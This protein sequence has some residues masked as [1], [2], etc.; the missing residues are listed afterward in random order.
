MDA[1]LHDPV[2]GDLVS[3]H[4]IFVQVVEV[5]KSCRRGQ[6]SV[7]FC[8]VLFCF[9]GKLFDAVEKTSRDI[10]QSTSIMTQN[11]VGHRLMFSYLSF[12]D[13]CGQ[14]SQPW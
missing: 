11:V 7:T 3:F 8:F 2:S 10:L 9:A 1:R 14:I 5:D 13:I 4:L 12:H 6:P